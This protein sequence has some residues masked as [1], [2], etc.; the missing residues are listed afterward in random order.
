VIA[1]DDAAPRGAGRISEAT[2]RPMTRPAAGIER[3]RPH[4]HLR[5]QGGRYDGGDL[6]R[7]RPRSPA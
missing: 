3:R 7:R 2:D 6:S 1:L 5:R 4:R